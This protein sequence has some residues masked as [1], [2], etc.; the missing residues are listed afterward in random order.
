MP[1][2]ILKDIASGYSDCMP[3]AVPAAKTKRVVNDCSGHETPT[4]LSFTDNR[5]KHSDAR[6]TEELLT[7]KFREFF[8]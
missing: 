5:D 3:N 6:E 1:S 2:N 4:L 8:P 7:R